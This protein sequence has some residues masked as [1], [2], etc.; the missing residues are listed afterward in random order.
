M[1]LKKKLS[2]K[3][4]TLTE[5]LTVI[6]IIM[7]LA[8]IVIVNLRGGQDSARDSTRIKDA[9]QI[10]NLLEEYY[11]KND[12][13]P[14]PSA[15]SNEEGDNNNWLQLQTAIGSLPR[16]PFFETDK[17]DIYYYTY[18]VG[19]EGNQEYVFMARLER[20]NKAVLDSSYKKK[21]FGECICT[22]ETGPPYIY[23]IKNP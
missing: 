8:G 20:E 12:S 19:G 21:D 22:Q 13:Y 16:D 17:K 14:E 2:E 18:C 11:L 10:V 1:D 7:I 9:Q 6:A 5:L 23:C 15:S 4:L 3:A